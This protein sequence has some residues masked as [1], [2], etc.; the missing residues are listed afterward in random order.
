MNHLLP[1]DIFENISAHFCLWQHHV[2]KCRQ[3]SCCFDEVLWW[4]WKNWRKVGKYLLTHPL[5]VAGVGHR[6]FKQLGHYTNP[7][8]A[9]H[10]STV[11]GRRD[12]MTFILSLVCGRPVFF[13]SQPRRHVMA[14]TTSPPRLRRGGVPPRQTGV[15]KVPV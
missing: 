9:S 15:T 5:N 8:R 7:K 6:L 4:T 13:L 12:A 3:S 14:R 2:L 11:H 1:L 10:T